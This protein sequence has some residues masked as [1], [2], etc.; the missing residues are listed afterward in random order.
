M[1]EKLYNS[2]TIYNNKVKNIKIVNFRGQIV[3]NYRFIS[4]KLK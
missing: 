2:I 1:H 3:T 4:I